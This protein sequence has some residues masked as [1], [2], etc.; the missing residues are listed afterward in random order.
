MLP[1]R[2]LSQHARRRVSSSVQNSSMLSLSNPLNL[3]SPA[4]HNSFS[5][6]RRKRPDMTST[7][8]TI[9]RDP[10]R[11]TSPLYEAFPTNE[12]FQPSETSMNDY[13]AKTS[14]SPWVP[15]PE[16][17]ARKIFDLVQPLSETDKHVDLGCG[18]GRVCF[19]AIDVAHLQQ[20]VGIDIDEAI[21][22][23]ARERLSKRR[24]S[25]IPN[26]LPTVE[27]V[28]AD[29]M[30][31]VTTDVWKKHIS[32]ATIITMF[33]ETSGLERLRP[34]LEEHLIGKSC[35]IVT[36]GY[37]MPGWES[38]IEEIVLGTTLYLYYW[39]MSPP[40]FADSGT[41][42]GIY[43]FPVTDDLHTQA[44]QSASE[45]RQRRALE[46][47]KMPGVNV[48]DRTKDRRRGQWANDPSNYDFDTD[49]ELVENE[50]WNSDEDDEDYPFRR[51]PIARKKAKKAS[52]CS[53]GGNKTEEDGTMK[54]G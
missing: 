49:D 37:P 38:T 3:M 33:M 42:A 5:T 4:P 24:P 28:Q 54:Q 45:M 8:K 51:R 30:D 50:R 18:D 7:R 40:Q 6:T 34:L 53:S 41:P 13:L 12:P 19:T 48:I 25:S 26:N 27:F 14:L 11:K 52:P 2:C 46:A 1:L 36:C 32:T 20:S 23:R 21:L 15:L 22:T 31:T 39:G 43:E 9:P 16:T 44:I 17:A 29:L 35:R 47:N 10:P